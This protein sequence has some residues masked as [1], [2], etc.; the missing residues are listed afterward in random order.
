MGNELR[1]L[2]E[3]VAV[4]NCSSIKKGEMLNRE[5]KPVAMCIN[6]CFTEKCPKEFQA[7]SSRS[8]DEQPLSIVGERS[9]NIHWCPFSLVIDYFSNSQ[10]I[11]PCDGTL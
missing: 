2:Q 8:V 1:H 7:H 6:Y 3:F 11:Q 5:K 9:L 10:T 4:L